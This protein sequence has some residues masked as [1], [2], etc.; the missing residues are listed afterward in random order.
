[1]W[2]GISKRQTSGSALSRSV[3]AAGMSSAVAM[4][5]FGGM[6][7][8][9]QN[10]DDPNTP[11]VS[12]G[13]EE[14][15]ITG[16]RLRRTGTETPSP[17]QILSSEDLHQSGYTSAQEV[18]SNL[19][20]NGQGTL[21]QGFSGAFASGASGVSL[22][23]LNV[24]ATL[25]L[26]DGHRTAPYPIGDDGS[27]SFVDTSNLPFEAIERIEVLKDGASALYGSDAIAG[28][29]NVILKEEYEGASFTADRG[30]SGRNDGTISHYSGI[31]GLG[32]L[33]NDG[34]NFYLTGEFRKQREIRYADRNGIFTETDFTSGGGENV[35]PGVPGSSAVA[36]LPQSNSGYIT[37]AGGDIIGFMPGCD[38]TSFDAGQCTFYDN[39][40]QIQPPTENINLLARYTQAF[41]DNWKASLQGGYFESNSE[42]VNG[43]S[44]AFTN[45]YQGLQ[46]G[47]GLTPT[48]L[49]PL[50]PTTIPNTNPSFPQGTPD[51]VANL[52][53]TLLNLGRGQITET[54]AKSY[55]AVTDLTGS[56][57]E[58]EL[59][60][61]IG[62]TEVKLDLDG[63]NYVNPTNLQIALND[64]TNPF[65]VGVQNTADVAEF[66]APRLKSRDRSRL[67]FGH[68]GVSRSLF[69][70]PG[71]PLGIAFGADYFSRDQDATAPGPVAAG[72]VPDFS[73]NFTIGTQHVSS[74]YVELAAPVFDSLEFD[75]AVRYDHYN[76]SGGEFSPK[77]GFKWQPLVEL[78]LRGTLSK[79]FRAP[80]PAENGESGQRFFAA[81]SADPILC[82]NPDNPN[83]PGNF[84]GQCAVNVPGLQTTNADLDPEE[85]TSFT[86]GLVLEPFENLTTSIDYYRIKIDDQIV[87]GGP[88]TQVRGTNLNPIAQFQADGTTQLVTPTAAPIG[89]NS[90][91]FVNAN[92]TETDGFEFSADYRIPL[93]GFGDWKSKA[94]VS[95]TN[96]YDITIDGTTYKLA[97]T[98]GPFFYS[99]NTGNPKT[100]FQWKNTFTRGQWEVSGT[101]NY[102]S[103]F[104]VTDPSSIAFVGAPQDTCLQ[105]LQTSGA[106][107]VNY[108]PLLLGGQIP[109]NVSCSVKHFTTFDLNGNYDLDE[110]IS[111]HASILNV[112]DESAPRDYQT[113]GGALGAVPYNPSLHSA[114]AI[115]RYFT[116]GV[117]YTFW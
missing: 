109:D 59:D 42:Q 50:D 85:S 96:H 10:T 69:E 95:Y 74:G 61:A 34:R 24:G 13:T 45:G 116:V 40:N 77:V 104:K 64:P 78:A 14:I 101:V 103:S 46:L 57:G 12:K 36:G 89:F 5:L 72:V 27:R 114:G 67:T 17:V 6:P 16:S 23:G 91:S 22:R 65:L 73:N 71:G 49:D 52:N 56:I 76:Q 99:G 79:G 112:F 1:M 26:I 110:N 33:D 29:V 54:E 28:V 55:R 100:R 102:I 113:Y 41:G 80:G 3:R 81:T 11:S 43:P 63:F 15:I 87:S 21:S 4:L 105:A 7:A 35:T 30:I 84:V 51:A 47:P 38:Q 39:Y 60:F 58:W 8:Q 92:E 68:A 117:T 93:G 83:A 19:T 82:P 53:Y 18:L 9:A 88:T 2:V 20:A 86:F 31:Y 98:H 115:G 48:F 70:L 75:G 106:A 62:Y 108:S 111:I 66:V 90:I 32:N 25:V 107:S 44:T 94:T 97:G 37:N